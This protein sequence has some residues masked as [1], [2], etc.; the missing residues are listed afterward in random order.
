ML[1][2]TAIFRALV[3]I[4]RTSNNFSVIGRYKIFEKV[5]GYT[6]VEHLAK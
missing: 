3:T 1:I 4:E 2:Q 6:T 5:V